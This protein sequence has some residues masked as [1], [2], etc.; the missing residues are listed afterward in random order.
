[1]YPRQSRVECIFLTNALFRNHINRMFAIAVEL[2]M[3]LRGIAGFLIAG[4]TL[5]GTTLYGAEHATAQVRNTQVRIGFA[6]G[7]QCLW[8]F[9]AAAQSEIYRFAPPAFSVDGKTVSAEVTALAAAGTPVAFANGVTEY[10]FE[11]PLAH[12]AHLHLVIQ[13]QVNEE[14]PVIRFRYL[15][16]SDSLQTMTMANGENRLTYFAVSLKQLPRA[17][18]ISFSELCTAYTQLYLV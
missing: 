6:C 11:G 17:E 13:F 3:P 14:T 5:C 10:S 1:M 18:E 4:L 8:S 9:S 7:S 15:L 2:W 16:K 12:D